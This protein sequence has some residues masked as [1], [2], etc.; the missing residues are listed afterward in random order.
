MKIHIKI[1]HR[2]QISIDVEAETKIGEIKKRLENQFNIPV[3]HQILMHFGVALADD[4][5]IGFYTRIKEGDKLNVVI[6]KMDRHLESIL[7]QLLKIHYNETQC[8]NIVLSF[9]N[10]L[11]D[12]LENMNYD[13][14]ERLALV[15]MDNKIL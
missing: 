6:R 11:Q 2:E 1:V 8:K 3:T 10:K 9:M 12:D 7:F 14:M 15:C 13:D 4:R 5:T